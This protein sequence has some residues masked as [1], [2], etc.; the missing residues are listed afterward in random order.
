MDSMMSFSDIYLKGWLFDNLT[1]FFLFW[2]ICFPICF[3]KV[4]I[5]QSKY[6][7]S[8]VTIQYLNI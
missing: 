6:C 1:F 3:W 8:Q 5:R 7:E 2:V 4:K